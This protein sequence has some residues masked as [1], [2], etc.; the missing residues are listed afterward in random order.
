MYVCMYVKLEI[1]N[2]ASVLTA[3]SQCSIR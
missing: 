3:R 2:S 1:T